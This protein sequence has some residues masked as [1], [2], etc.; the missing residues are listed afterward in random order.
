MKGKKA[1]GNPTIH[2]NPLDYARSYSNHVPFTIFFTQLI[3]PQL[4]TSQLLLTFIT[5]IFFNSAAIMTTVVPPD[6][7][8]CPISQ[9]LTTDPVVAADGH[10][11]DRRYIEDWINLKGANATSPKTN[12]R[13]VHHHLIPNHT[14]KSGIGD[15]YETQRRQLS[16]QQ[17]NQAKPESTPNTAAAITAEHSSSLNQPAAK[18]TSATSEQ[19]LLAP[20]SASKRQV[21]RAKTRTTTPAAATSTAAATASPPSSPL[22]TTP[23]TTTA[24]LWAD[25][26]SSG[27]L[28]M[29]T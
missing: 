13:L 16:S 28:Y 24:I 2:V 15:F 3:L 22:K 18:A 19:P 9:E 27:R 20:S 17:S 26:L 12:E 10:T 4:S 14:L 21:A 23:A 7:F 1:A 8:V 29:E 6:I 11:Y 5:C 25:F